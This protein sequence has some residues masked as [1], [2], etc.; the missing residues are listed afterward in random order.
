MSGERRNPRQ[1]SR[2]PTAVPGA[3]AVRAFLKNHPDFLVDNPDLLEVLTPPT[4][5]NGTNVTD[6]GRFMARRLQEEVARLKLERHEMVN[7]GRANQSAQEQVH[8]A[9]TVMLE[10]TSFEHLVHIV[11]R[12]LADVLDV[13]VVTLCAEARQGTALPGQ[14]PTAGVFV[15]E[16]GSIDLLLG[17]GSRA[18][19]GNDLSADPAIFGPAAGLVR[20][21]ALVRLSASRRAPA[22]LLAIGSREDDKFDAGHGTELLDFMAR[23]LERLFRAWLDLPA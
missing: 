23:V 4:Q 22:G 18:R 14:A 2:A 1:V 19:L 20:S 9:I 8:R 5:H 10:A 7:L 12:D 13:D 17:A 3:A 6:M 11:T 15:L 21:Q 16:P